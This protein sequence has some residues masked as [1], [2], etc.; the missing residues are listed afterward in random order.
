MG[1]LPKNL[2]SITE[3]TLD[4]KNIFPKFSESLLPKSVQPHPPMLTAETP[5]VTFLD[6]RCTPHKSPSTHTH[7][8][9]AL[10]PKQRLSCALQVCV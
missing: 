6:D 9:A 1:L 8:C 3:L 10:Q 5:V 7:R 4:F 2:E